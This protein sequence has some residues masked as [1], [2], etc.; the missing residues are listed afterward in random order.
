MVS[1]AALTLTLSAVFSLIV[2]FRRYWRL[3]HI[4]GPFLASVTDLWRAK[5]QRSGPTKPWLQALH[6]QHGSLVRIGPN[7]ISVSDAASMKIVFSSK[8]DF[9]KVGDTM[10]RSED[11]AKALT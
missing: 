2:V 4:P 9:R 7:T 1:S 5:K 10:E 3:R 6:Q 8:G 11:A